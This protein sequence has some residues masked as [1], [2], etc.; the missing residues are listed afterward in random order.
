MRPV[1]VGP[2]GASLAE[3]DTPTPK[4]AEVLVRVRAAALNRADLAVAAGQPHGPT[5]GPGAIV[6]LEWA[7]EV[8]SVGAAVSDFHPGD[9]VMCSGAGGYA[10]YAVAD[11][12]GPFRFPRTCRSRSPRPCRS[13]CRR[14]TTP[15]SR[16]RTYSRARPC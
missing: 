8:V 5:G 9:R 13:P 6:G 11:H 7:G 3:T 10:E 12:G 16:R 2:D 1:V 15:S 14:C 4:P